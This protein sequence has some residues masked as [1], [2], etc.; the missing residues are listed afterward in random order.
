MSQKKKSDK[1]SNHLIFPRIISRHQ[2][3][4]QGSGKD[5]S[6]NVIVKVFVLSFV[7][8]FSDSDIIL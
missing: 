3:H 7:L 5:F 4:P 8:D 2:R 1:K 6:K